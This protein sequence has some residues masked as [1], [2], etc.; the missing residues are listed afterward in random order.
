MHMNYWSPD[1]STPTLQGPGEIR[2]YDCGHSYDY[3]G[4]SSH[5]GRCPACDAPGV[6]PA[7]ELT[8]V[9]PLTPL[10]VGPGDSTHR[11]DATDD[12]GRSFCY[13]L[14]TIDDHR[15]QLVRVGVEDVVVGPPDDA[16]PDDLDALI[17]WWLASVVESA[18]MELVAPAAIL[19]TDDDTS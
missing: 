10:V 1:H 11:I 14:S 19:E 2:C 9:G 4:P 15:V 17:P 3:L 7:G 13:W 12:S 18:S 5:P 16:W 8:R 6:S